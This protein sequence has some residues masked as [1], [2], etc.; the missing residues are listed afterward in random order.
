MD[1]KEIDIYLKKINE[2]QDK[3]EKLSI[4][5]EF[6]D[7]IYNSIGF[8]NQN[9]NVMFL[10][11]SNDIIN[12]LVEISG[13]SII[14]EIGAAYIPGLSYLMG[15]I[16][17][18]SNASNKESEATKINKHVDGLLS[19]FE[20]LLE[21]PTNEQIDIV[22][23]LLVKSISESLKSNTPITE[24]TQLATKNFFYKLPN[25]TNF[26]KTFVYSKCI[27][28]NMQEREDV[29]NLIPKLSIE[30]YREIIR[31]LDESD[32]YF[33]YDDTVNEY[34]SFYGESEEVDFDEKERLFYS[35][36]KKFGEGCLID[37]N[38]YSKYFMKTETNE[39]LTFLHAK[40]SV[41]MR[42]VL[43]RIFESDGTEF[44]TIDYEKKYFE[45]F[46]LP[47]NY[48]VKNGNEEFE[49]TYHGEF[50]EMLSDLFHHDGEY[51]ADIA[52]YSIRLKN[53]F[54]YKNRPNEPFLAKVYDHIKTLDI[55][56]SLRENL[57][58]EKLREITLSNPETLF[59]IA[60]TLGIPYTEKERK[61]KIDFYNDMKD[62]GYDPNISNSGLRRI[63][64]ADIALSLMLESDPTRAIS[65]FYDVQ[66]INSFSQYGKNI[67]D[68]RSSRKLIEIYIDNKFA[69]LG[70]QI[71][72]L[73]KQIVNQI[74]LNS[75][76]NIFNEREISE[77]L[78]IGYL[79]R[80]KFGKEI[81][82]LVRSN[83]LKNPSYQISD[84]EARSNV[85]EFIKK[86]G[87]NP[88]GI[89]NETD[90]DKFLTSLTQIRINSKDGIMPEEVV[91]FLINQSLRPDSIINLKNDKYEKVPER[92]IEDLGKIDITR[93][94]N[95]QK[96]EY[97]YITRDYI[98]KA[99]V[100][101]QQSS[102]NNN[103]RVII[104]TA[105]IKRMSKGDI[106]ALDT[107]FHEN[108]HVIRK[109]KILEPSEEY[110]EYLMKKELLIELSEG[111][112]YYNRNYKMF[113][114][115]IEARQMGARLS[116]EYI[117]K[118]ISQNQVIDL[119]NS[120]RQNITE[121]LISKFENQRKRYSQIAIRE[122]N[123]YRKGLF[124]KDTDG[125]TRTI[126]EIFDKKVQEHKMNFA[127][128]R[129]IEP[130]AVYEYRF[131][132]Q[133]KSF[134]EQI[135]TVSNTISDDAKELDFI[136]AIINYSGTSKDADALQ[137][138]VAIDNL[139]DTSGDKNSNRSK[140]IA[141]IIGPNLP[142][143]I[144]R[145]GKATLGSLKSGQKPTDEM[146]EVYSTIQDI[147]KK[148]QEE[149][150]ADWSKGF[151]QQNNKGKHSLQLMCTYCDVMKYYYPA[152]NENVGTAKKT[153]THLNEKKNIGE[154]IKNA[155]STTVKNLF[156][157]RHLA[158]I[159]ADVKGKNN[160]RE[161]E[162]E[163]MKKEN[164]KQIKTEIS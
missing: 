127:T 133:K 7:L 12:Y 37:S 162:N 112:A 150:G 79:E 54:N 3:A 81:L 29:K 106:S 139:I 23:F 78:Q 25:L 158:E 108:T 93:R 60:E 18:R 39:N 128:F 105:K 117:G 109:Y 153:T 147:I 123:S 148:I 98:D 43:A 145:Y 38:T 77:L 161:F 56:D 6:L 47:Y 82:E 95:K 159:K 125:Q 149:P 48:K 132:G 85:N 151:M 35:I 57:N 8:V 70:R 62:N 80:T 44:R 90:F 66:N 155:V 9:G 163:L 154:R 129:N 21:N 76:F 55:Y 19:N 103:K 120:L 104:K 61:R 42:E 68:S 14:N 59:E 140:F 26:R 157:Y 20:A 111:E 91:D 1:K 144:A 96:L 13:T 28:D 116:A 17:N 71:E 63:D 146:I 45:M 141:E 138:L 107:L 49:E 5:R 69:N 101:G 10:K 114:E 58:P 22:D 87:T 11:N 124:K 118:I 89:D 131:D 156:G 46:F 88:I 110:M 67:Y 97:I 134:P 74:T 51:W 121:T 73:I 30:E 36:V 100:N 65:E 27:L 2:T 94:Y 160:A 99:D 40:K 34:L 33:E 126:N 135:N 31:M 64:V 152:I 32:D 136:R 50:Q 86:I 92:A 15:E 83:L 24:K 52:K 115:E 143:I 102:D 130:M 41:I 84:E 16:V 4:T 122:F 75:N 119:A 72:P 164:E 137:T 113:L 53:I 142:D